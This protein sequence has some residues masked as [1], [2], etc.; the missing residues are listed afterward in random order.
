MLKLNNLADLFIQ[1]D[2]QKYISQK[3]DKQYIAVDTIKMLIETG[4]Q[5]I[6]ITSLLI[7]SY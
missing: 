3:E 1:S 6:T 5:N 2:I 7:N 4:A